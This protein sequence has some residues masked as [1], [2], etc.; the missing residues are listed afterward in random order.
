MVHSGPRNLA[1]GAA[2][3]DT[4]NLDIVRLSNRSQKL[5]LVY[6]RFAGISVSVSD[7]LDSYAICDWTIDGHLLMQQI[8]QYILRNAKNKFVVCISLDFP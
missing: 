8:T 6:R 4:Q 1:C 3:H 7:W 2:G 5:N